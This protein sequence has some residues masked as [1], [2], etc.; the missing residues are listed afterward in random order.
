[1]IP[2]IVGIGPYSKVS[3][4]IFS[5]NPF[6]KHKIISDK[7]ADI[8]PESSIL[9]MSQQQCFGDPRLRSLQWHFPYESVSITFLVGKKVDNPTRGTPLNPH[10]VIERCLLQEMDTSDPQFFADCPLWDSSWL[11]ETQ[12]N[13]H[14]NRIISPLSPVSQ[15]HDS[16]GITGGILLIRYTQC[17]WS[18]TVFAP[19]SLV[20][21]LSNQVP[22]MP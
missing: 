20:L 4:L 8:L 9:R 2:L 22:I 13:G 10:W 21:L 18:S 7:I 19:S 1:M 5:T 6:F 15:L 14:P 11:G 12:V 17:C 3:T 16:G